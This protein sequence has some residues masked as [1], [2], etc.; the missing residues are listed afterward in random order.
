MFRK[1]LFILCFILLASSSNAEEAKRFSLE[2]QDATRAKPSW[3]PMK[4]IVHPKIGLALSGGVRGLAHIGVLKALVKA[5]IPIDAIVGTSLGSVVGGLYAAGYSP[6]EIEG[7]VSQ[8]DWNSL[9]ED[10]P[11]RSSLFI[12]QKTGLPKSIIQMRFNRSGFLLPSALSTGQK[13]SNLLSG[14]TLQADLSSNS[15]FNN[16]N[17]PFRAVATDIVTGQ[18]VV[19]SEGNLSEAIRASMAV[20]LVLSPVNKGELRL[21]DGGLSDNMPVDVTRDMGMDFVIAVDVT[22]HMRSPENIKSPIQMMDQVTTIMMAHSVE[23]QLRFADFVIRPDLPDNVSMKYKAMKDLITLGE[24]TTE[25]NIPALMKKLDTLYEKASQDTEEVFNVSAIKIEGNH[26]IH[27][28][29]I[30]RIADISTGKP[31]RSPSILNAMKRIYQT[32]YFSNLS[33]AI[34]SNLSSSV[35][36]F[37]VSENPILK[38]VK[39]IGNTV[40]PSDTLLTKVR[41]SFGKVINLYKGQQDLALIVEHYRQNGF[42][43]ARI[44]NVGFDHN[45][46][47]SAIY[48]DEGRIEGIDV[49]GN[50]KTMRNVILREFPLKPGD[51]FNLTQTD[52]GV[53]NIYAAGLFETVGLE[54]RKATKGPTLIL[55]VKEHQGLLARIGLRFDLEYKSE[56]F[57]E[58]LNDNVFGTG[59]DFSIFAKVGDRYRMYK[60]DYKDN[61]IFDSYLTYDLHIR[62]AFEKRLIYEDGEEIDEFQDGREGAQLSLGEQI[63]RMGVVTVGLKAENISVE[64][65]TIGPFSSSKIKLR[66]LNINS[67]LDNLDRYPF[68]RTG[69]QQ[70]I[71]LE[72]ASASFGGTQSYTKFLFA[73][74]YYKTLKKKH[75]FRYRLVWGAADLTLPLVEGFRLGGEKNLIGYKED[76]FLGRQLFGG[77]LE[78]R[79]WIPKYFYGSLRYDFGNVWVNTQKIKLTDVHHS[80]GLILAFDTPAGPVALS[81]GRS[82]EGRY[83]IYFSAGYDF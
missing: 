32:G 22:G 58:I 7:L 28:D 73:G 9:F 16:L 1:I 11:Q 45:T 49:E 34:E 20:P 42:V 57:A 27:I 36:V 63:Y 24:T 48:L 50:S 47:I 79:L 26:N 51:V 53:D 75:T 70:V 35:L 14:L 25:K 82:T 62:R 41:R 38:G 72:T 74:D 68:P 54:V 2:L 12:G 81:Y 65:D 29:E 76:E 61:R 6:Q 13:L 31:L 52:K 19:I 43:L 83:G 30:L 3:L 77:S 5:G 60:L 69:R 39:L 8:L 56:A 15:N 33:V 40:F 4:E 71:S 59:A 23:E 78:Y 44:V 18:K 64:S 67:V 10:T 37:E 66:S 46:G 17:I 21:V 55:K 80:L